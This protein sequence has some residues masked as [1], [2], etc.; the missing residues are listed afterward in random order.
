M[1]V[2][3]IIFTMQADDNGE[4]GI[5]ALYAL[6]CRASNIRHGASMTEADLSLT[7]YQAGRPPGGS[8]VAAKLRGERCAPTAVGLP[9]LPT[10]W[11]VSSPV[12]CRCG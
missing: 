1:L 7:Q 10:V 11:I 6:I 5:F 8:R 2:K 4:G 12:P 9:G 3:Y